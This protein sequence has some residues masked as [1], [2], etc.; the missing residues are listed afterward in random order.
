MLHCDLLPLGDLLLR[1][2]PANK[3]RVDLKVSLTKLT[4][5]TQGISGLDAI[6]KNATFTANVNDATVS[7]AKGIST[8]HIRFATGPYSL[9]FDGNVRLADEA[10]VGMNLSI[11]PLQSLAQRV[12]GIHDPAVLSALQDRIVIPVEGSVQHAR[13]VPDKVFKS[14]ADATAKAAGK[15]LLDRLTKKKK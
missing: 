11:G 5:G 13:I 4:I 6:L 9:D 3:G 14:I 7:I 12:L 10:L 1:N 8:Q 15:G 2:A